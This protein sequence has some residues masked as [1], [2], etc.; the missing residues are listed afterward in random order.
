MP[1]ISMRTCTLPSGEA[2]PV[3]GQGTWHMGEH[4]SRRD[5]EI[6]ALRLGLRATGFAFGLAP[7][8]LGGFVAA[9]FGALPRATT[10]PWPLRVTT[11]TVR[12][13]TRFPVATLR[14]GSLI[15]TISARTAESVSFSTVGETAGNT[16]VSPACSANS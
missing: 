14:I 8:A 2:V 13:P 1:K 16:A 4:P 5:Q 15:S 11:R 7:A 6:A 3:L 10:L 12:L 9:A